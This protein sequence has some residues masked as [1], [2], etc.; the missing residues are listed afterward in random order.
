MKS[1]FLS[2]TLTL[3]MIVMSAVQV[4]ISGPSTPLF[5]ETSLTTE[6]NWPPNVRSCYN[7]L[8]SSRKLKDCRDSSRERY[9]LTDADIQQCSTPSTEKSTFNSN[10]CLF[11]CFAF[12]D[13]MECFNHKACYYCS[14]NESLAFDVAVQEKVSNFKNEKGSKCSHVDDY[15]VNRTRCSAGGPK[16]EIITSGSSLDLSFFLVVIIC[17]LLFCALLVVCGMMVKMYI[18]GNLFEESSTKKQKEKIKGNV[19]S[20]KKEY[21][22]ADF[23]DPKSKKRRL[24]SLKSSWK[25]KT[26][27]L[28]SM[29]TSLVQKKN[30]ETSKKGKLSFKSAFK[31]SKIKEQQS[32]EVAKSK[33]S[34]SNANVKR[35]STGAKA[36]K[37]NA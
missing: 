25:M 24:T 27:Q 32:S 22:P 19:E 31:S 1:N 23:M 9:N 20:A 37:S 15:K 10:N 33:L 6:V 13:Q 21:G 5:S 16:T 29:K 2:L 12:Y 8:F 36:S 14:A 35:S 4:I 34:S 18:T 26:S 3:M 11:F 30:K 28:K 17:C 7:E